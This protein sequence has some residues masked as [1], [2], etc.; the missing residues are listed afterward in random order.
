MHCQI[1]HE[2]PKV[3]PLLTRE[4]EHGAIA[5]LANLGP[6]ELDGQPESACPLAGEGQRILLALL[7]MLGARQV[8]RLGLADHPAAVSLAR[9][10]TWRNG[11]GGESRATSIIYHNLVAM[12]QLH[13][14]TIAIEAAPIAGKAHPHHI[15]HFPGGSR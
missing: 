14:R 5:A 15:A 12:A 11:H 8:A 10:H 3:D 13:G 7:V 4:E 1:T 6:K 9:A 2:S